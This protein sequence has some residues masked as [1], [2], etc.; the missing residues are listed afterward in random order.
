MLGG[1]VGAAGKWRNHTGVSIESRML[2][3]W[4]RT[5]F[6]SD[7]LQE[8][9]SSAGEGGEQVVSRGSC[10]TNNDGDESRLRNKKKKKKCKC[11][12]VMVVALLRDKPASR[13]A[14]RTNAVA[15][16]CV[17]KSL[18]FVACGKSQTERMLASRRMR[19][20]DRHVVAE[21]NRTRHTREYERCE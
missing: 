3:G 10:R 15:S 2:V 5:V 7:L 18:F 6:L 19:R 4:R 16:Q 8:D 1:V 17:A 20:T 21:N 9:S 13:C 11:R 12:E 14:R